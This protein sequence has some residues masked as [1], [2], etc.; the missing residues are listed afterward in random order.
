[1]GEAALRQMV[2]IVYLA[3]W[4]IFS[5]LSSAFQEYLFILQNCF[6]GTV[7]I[8]ADCFLELNPLGAIPE[9][10]KPLGFQFNK[11]CRFCKDRV[12][13]PITPAFVTVGEQYRERVSCAMTHA[14]LSALL[15]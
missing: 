9:R 6:G 10:D 14:L 12:R 13:T 11:L 4:F 2:C 3:D 7:I 15:L 8:F 5:P 1:M